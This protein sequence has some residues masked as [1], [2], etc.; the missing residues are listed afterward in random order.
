MNAEL[1]KES[2]LLD[3]KYGGMAAAGAAN[4]DPFAA[5]E[6]GGGALPVVR[7]GD[8]SVAAPFTSRVPSVRSV[9]LL[10]RQGRSTL[11]GALQ[12]H[13]TM[14]IECVMHAYTHALISLEG[15]RSSERQLMVSGWLIVAASVAFSYG[16]PAEKMHPCR[17]LKSIF[18]P[19]IALSIA[20]QCAI[21]LLALSVASAMAKKAMGPELI[22]QVIAFQKKVSAG[23]L[24]EEDKYDEDDPLKA[25]AS[26]WG[27]PFM[28]NLM[29][30][31]VFLV[32]TAQMVAVMLVN[33]KGR[34]FTKGLLENH[35]LFMSLF[36]TV[37]WV[38]F[39]AWELNPQINHALHFHAFPDDAFR[40]SV[41]GLLTAVLVG[42][43]VWDRLCVWV[44]A[45]DVFRASLEAARQTTLRDLVP[46][47]GTLVKV[48]VGLAV[49]ASANPLIWGAAYWVNKKFNEKME[50]EDER[51]RERERREAGL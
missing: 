23:T 15:S 9:V 32:E 35:V 43:F 24:K 1:M 45:P 34:P 6:E 26:M 13:Q 47:L 38:V 49:F 14:M 29:N 10:I 27:Q 22:A 48:V 21:H 30:T 17:P 33:Y 12:Q 50:E 51:R 39:T 5:L 37:G 3:A 11:L 31:T 25:L 28:P 7:P 46:V 19:A 40:W 2:A 4:N 44:F 36:S 8:A 42:T 41:L 18:H 20:G 16:T